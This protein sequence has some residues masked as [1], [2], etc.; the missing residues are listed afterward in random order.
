MSGALRWLSPCP[1]CFEFHD[2]WQ[3]AD[4]FS[5]TTTSYHDGDA[6]QSGDI[7]HDEDSWMQTTVS[8]KGNGELLLESIV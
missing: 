3:R 1:R 8:G 4:W 6:T 2:G 7:S 5:Q